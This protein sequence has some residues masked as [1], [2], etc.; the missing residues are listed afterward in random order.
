MK[1]FSRFLP[2]IYVNDGQESKEVPK[3]KA[4]RIKRSAGREWVISLSVRR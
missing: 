3:F 4:V 1:L 2:S